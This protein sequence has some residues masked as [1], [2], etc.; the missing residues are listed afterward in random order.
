MISLF[1]YVCQG[2]F[3]HPLPHIAK[4]EAKE[5]CILTEW[6]CND[7]NNNIMFS[8]GFFL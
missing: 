7:H 2:T 6:N 8:L 3:I 5:R 1:H 4:R